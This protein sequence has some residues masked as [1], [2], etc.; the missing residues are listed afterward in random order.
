M[1][2]L[3]A[4]IYPPVG[5]HFS[6][7][8]ELFPQT[9]QD[10]RFQSM[11]GLNVEIPL[12]TVTGGGENRFKYQL[13]N[14]P[15]YGKLVLKRGM[16]SGSLMINWV[17]NAVEK[18]EFDPKNVIVTLLNDL[19]LPV[20]VWQVFNAYPVKWAVSDF[21]AEQNTIVIET[22]E[23]CYQHFQQVGLGDLI[24]GNISVSL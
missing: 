2:L 13:P 18:F 11:S 19:H 15:Q 24:G 8:I 22:I 20:T 14:T 5:F 6:V 4:F 1:S 7:V 12:E 16:F 10:F 9:P 17:R 21:D 3:D 23:L